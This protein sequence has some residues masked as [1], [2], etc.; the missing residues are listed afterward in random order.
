MEM[1]IIVGLGVAGLGYIIW[2]E[3]E[4]SQKKAMAVALVKEC[5]NLVSLL[6]QSDKNAQDLLAE[7]KKSNRVIEIKDKEL[8]QIKNFLV[9]DPLISS[10][11]PQRR[12]GDRFNQ[13]AQ[14]PLDHSQGGS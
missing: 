13:S 2:M 5:S 4:I 11:H 9:P 10:K 3:R 6:R 12:L 7:L 8:A 1:Y 14:V